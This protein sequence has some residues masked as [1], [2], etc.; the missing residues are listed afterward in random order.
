MNA[1]LCAIHLLT[2]LPVPSYTVNEEIQRQSLYWHGA[3]GL[4]I[5]ITLWLGL[6]IFQTV[7]PAHHLLIAAL[8]LLQ[9]VVITGAL[10]LDGLGD[11]AD[12]WLGGYGNKAKTLAIM[13]DPTSGPAAIVWIVLLLL[14]KFAALV[15]LVQQ[16]FHLAL[17]FAPLMARLGSMNLFLAVPYVREGGIAA[18]FAEKVTS[19]WIYGQTIIVLIALLI[20]YGL[21]G[22]LIALA[23]V[24]G[25][26]YLKTLMIHRIQG[27]TGDTAGA[28][29]ECLEA[30]IL[31]SFVIEL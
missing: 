26:F 12:A 31:V 6:L 25:W 24:L 28:L 13:K 7:L 2:R 9:W 11:S 21:Q 20:L 27:T 30:L 1:F 3:V 5:G 15:A 23:A 16:Q 18:A 14:I 17:V 29:I 10:H 19:Q 8:L 22:A 4:L